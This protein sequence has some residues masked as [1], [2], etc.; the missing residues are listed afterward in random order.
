M[1]SLITHGVVALLAARGV[2][3]PLKTRRF[4][5]L[6]VVVSCLPDVDVLGLY[7]GIPY[8]ALFGHRG[9]THSLFFAVLTGVA[10]TSAA[11]RSLRFGT[12]EWWMTS[13]FY[14]AVTASHGCFDAMTDGGLGVAFFSPFS[15]AR[16]FFPWQP[17]VVSPLTA[18]GF[19]NL[20]GVVILINEALV[21]VV[22]A[23]LAVRAL[24]LYRR[25]P[26]IPRISVV[27]L[28]VA[29]AVWVPILVVFQ[30]FLESQ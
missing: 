21:I 25:R 20:L 6:A 19:I 24:E 29:V 27:V 14:F 13:L 1:A 12:R 11:F 15:N 2:E 3:S 10:V 16:F 4:W 28:L 5:V 7:A 9:F 18:G 17:I 22:P 26:A 23:Y 30:R 8:G